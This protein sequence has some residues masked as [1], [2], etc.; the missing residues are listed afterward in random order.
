MWR[1][2][3]ASTLGIHITAVRPKPIWTLH[4]L[5]VARHDSRS[6]TSAGDRDN[7]CLVMADENSETF[8][9]NCYGRSLA[10][11]IVPQ[12]FQHPAKFSRKLIERLY[13]HALK[14]RWLK[15]GDL[16]LDPLAG[17]CVGGVAAAN[18]GL[19]WIGVELEEHWAELGRACLEKHRKT[20][21]ALGRPMPQIIQGDARGLL[22]VLASGGQIA[23]VV[24]SPPYADQAVSPQG[25][26]PDQRFNQ[27]YKVGRRGNLPRERARAGYSAI[28]SSP[29]FAEQR[30]GAGLALPDACHLDGHK[31]GHNL[32]YQNQ[33]DAPGQLASLPLGDVQAVISSPPYVSGGHH[34]DQTGSWGGLQME[35]AVGLGTKEVAGYGLTPDQIGRMPEGEIGAV[36]M[37][38][39]YEASLTP[40]N[41]TPRQPFMTK[42]GLRNPTPGSQAGG[43]PDRYSFDKQN[44]GNMS[45]ET[46]WS[47]MAQIYQQCH[48]LLPPG[49]H[50][51]LV[52]KPF[53]RNKAICDL[54]GQTC[55][56]LEA[57]GFRVLHRHRAWL[58]AREAQRRF[59]GGED[60]REWKSFFRRLQEGKGSPRI[61]FECVI[62]AERP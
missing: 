53:I 46:Y 20:W 56:L 10:P 60:R 62:C 44:I 43:S 14:E 33:G 55:Q 19:K 54:P 5:A 4:A 32:G 39:P 12:A 11:W 31:F 48:A 59:D 15:P 45:G 26:G 52:V 34:P 3:R 35:K 51:I 28:V 16:V 8:W 49:G 50:I 41:K 47:A 17:V 42:R 24:S 6:T 58:V 23:G 37:S 27:D 7:L 9:F 38:P 36:V 13:A 22:D 61:D 1:F 29:P 25:G 18:A 30:R 2:T 57:V 21:E 40:G